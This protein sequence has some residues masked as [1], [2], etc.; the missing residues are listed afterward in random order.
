MTEDLISVFGLNQLRINRETGN[1][2]RF[3]SLTPF[4]AKSIGV[5]AADG[6]AV[7]WW[8]VSAEYS[9]TSWTP[10]GGAVIDT[11]DQDRRS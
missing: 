3:T 9:D 7:V 1:V 4:R 6:G 8:I 11:L 10:S 2:F 5:T